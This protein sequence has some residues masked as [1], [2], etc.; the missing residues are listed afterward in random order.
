MQQEAPGGDPVSAPLAD[1]VQEDPGEVLVP[2]QVF[3]CQSRPGGSQQAQ[4][5][6]GKVPVPF[7]S[8]PLP[9]LPRR[10][11]ARNLCQFRSSSS[12]ISPR[13]LLARYLC[14]FRLS[15]L[16]NSPR[17]LPARYLGQFRSSPSPISPR[18]IP[19]RYLCQLS[20][21]PFRLGGPWHLCQL[22]LSCVTNPP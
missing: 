10:L 13:R 3:P 9:I 14:Q 1:F 15:P 19:A 2:V 18:R 6:L 16:L 20:P 11:P 17:R 5:A 7:R 22:R 12:P 8:S 4:E 21:C